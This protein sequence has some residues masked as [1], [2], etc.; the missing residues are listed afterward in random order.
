MK[1]T[2]YDCCLDEPDISPGD[3]PTELPPL[4]HQDEMPLSDIPLETPSEPPA[5]EIPEILPSKE[6]DVIWLFTTD[7]K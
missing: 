5:R 2:D 7:V 6:K 4:K 3:I 1:I